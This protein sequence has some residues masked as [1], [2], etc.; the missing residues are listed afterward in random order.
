MAKNP[1]ID[2]EC[3]ANYRQFVAQKILIEKHFPCFAC[4]FSNRRL[5]CIGEITPSDG[6][7]TYGIAISYQCGGVP[8]VTI[9]N[10]RII[11]SAKIH[12]YRNG[13][14]C[15][16]FPPQDPWKVTDNIHKK[17]IPWTAE[18]LVF[19]ELFKRCGKWLGPEAPHHL[20]EK[21]DQLKAA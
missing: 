6:C 13:T 7:D 10:P 3:A 15:L 2:G 1:R 12:M 16:Y 19:Y 18:W 20:G 8:Q 14:L 9:K 4:R 11:P 5:E 17:I 21:K